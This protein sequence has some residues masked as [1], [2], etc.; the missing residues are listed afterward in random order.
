MST[1]LLEFRGVSFGYT[2]GQPV[3]HHL[4][5]ALEPGRVTA[6]M[7]P[8]GVG[9]TTLLKLAL[10]VLAPWEGEVLLAGRAVR[11]MKR[12]E[13]G[14]MMALVPQNEHTPFDYAVLDY[15]LMGRAPH[16]HPLGLPGNREIER[17]M[18][19][20]RQVGLEPLAETPVP[21]L[22]GGEHQL[23]LLARALLQ[24]PR[25]L[26][27]DEPTA[28]LDLHNKMRMIEMG[29]QVSAQGMTVLMTNHEP[30]V[31][32][33]LAQDVLLMGESG[34]TTFG[35]LEET[36]TAERLSR[37]YGLKV[38]L[39]EVDGRRQVLWT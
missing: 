9:K 26:I 29:R 3:I 32:L 31:V 17:A 18:D 36:F 10:G 35:P 20:L 7:G 37:M 14:R 15:V 2:A 5:L 13:V 27:L 24:E 21:Q 11:A 34:E 22:S 38:R 25:L 6:I 23:M 12:P 19:A 1:A 4:D 30:E 8:N 16:M 28:H 39:V 33:A